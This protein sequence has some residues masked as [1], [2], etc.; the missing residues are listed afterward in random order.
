MGI[1][2][3][4]IV[5]VMLLVALSGCASLSREECVTG[6]WRGI[7]YSDGLSGRAESYLA[8]HQTACAEYQI[9]LNLVEYNQG[10]AEGLTRYC[11]PENGYRLG[12]QGQKYNYVCP[13]SLEPSFLSQ[14][15]QGYQ[16][17]QQA[18]KVRQLEREIKQAY[19]KQE[20]LDEQQIDAEAKLVADGRNSS[21]RKRLLQKLK[22]IE[23][24]RL[25]L[26][27]DLL[28][29]QQRLTQ[30]QFELQQAQ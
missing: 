16:L 30:A 8:E 17:F 25:R 20:N 4:H 2:M 29:L 3:R 26:Q 10:R 23:S 11:Q 14:Y 28:H 15:Q 18:E 13:A 21:E 5:W 24:E 12:R 6:D 19:A 22:T 7:G 1:D 9:S 27:L